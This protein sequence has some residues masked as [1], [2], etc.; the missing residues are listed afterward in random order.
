[1][2]ESSPATLELPDKA[3]QLGG[4]LELRLDSI[5]GSSS[6]HSLPGSVVAFHCERLRIGSDVGEAPSGE[7]ALDPEVCPD[8]PA[9][10]IVID[11]VPFPIVSGRVGLSRHSNG[12]VSVEMEGETE[13]IEYSGCDC[14][15][16]P[17]PFTLKGTARIIKEA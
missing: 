3:I 17:I 8:D 10:E 12:T 16:R 9:G 6:L 5:D 7:F 13:E 2:A 14:V 4:G 15:I 11:G 1:M